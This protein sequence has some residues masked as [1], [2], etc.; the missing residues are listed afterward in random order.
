MLGKSPMIATAD[1]DMINMS[2]QWVRSSIEFLF[3]GKVPESEF[4]Y[5]P[6]TMVTL[7]NVAQAKENF[8]SSTL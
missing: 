1:Q 5:T 3:D 8:F 2:V 6:V 7:E 4:L